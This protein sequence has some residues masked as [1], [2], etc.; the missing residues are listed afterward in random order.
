MIVE[1]TEKGHGIAEDI[2]EQA[3]YVN[4]NIAQAYY[5]AARLYDSGS[6][7]GSN[8]LELARVGEKCYSSDVANLLMGWTDADYKCDL[9]K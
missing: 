8:A 7:D 5:R 4:G 6:I 9:D 3:G 2:N 1:G